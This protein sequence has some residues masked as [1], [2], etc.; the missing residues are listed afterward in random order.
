MG[1]DSI[2]G[3]FLIDQAWPNRF[4]RRQAQHR[5]DRLENELSGRASQLGSTM[6]SGACTGVG[7]R[8]RAPAPPGSAFPADRDASG[9]WGQAEHRV[10]AR[11]M[12]QVTVQSGRFDPAGGDA[13]HA[14]R[15]TRISLP[16]NE[17]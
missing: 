8:I 6:G 1:P 17:P 4:P 11:S 7:S 3:R 16:A 14:G 15:L 9:A 10:Q 2:E 5:Q 13:L 12:V